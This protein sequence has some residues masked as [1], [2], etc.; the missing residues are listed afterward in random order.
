[1]IPVLCSINMRRV[2]IM[3]YMTHQLGD[4]GLRVGD[5]D[6]YAAHAAV[7]PCR[8]TVSRGVGSE[9]DCCLNHSA[10][11]VVSCSCQ[12]LRGVWNESLVQQPRSQ[13][14][15]GCLTIFMLCST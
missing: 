12:N 3:Q 11:S 15:A 1:M 4:A 6:A 13:P 2:K 14:D 5:S 8:H 7:V 10:Q 9:A